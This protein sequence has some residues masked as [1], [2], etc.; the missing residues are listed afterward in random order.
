V[1]CQ[2]YRNVEAIFIDD[3]STDKTAEIIK[4]LITQNSKNEN[5][6]K[7][8]LIINPENQNVYNSRN[9]G[10]K[11]SSGE[12][13]TYLDADD[14][15]LPESME[16]FA[17]FV[18]EFDY[19][20]IIC[21]QYKRIENG[22]LVRQAQITAPPE[23]VDD[24]SKIRKTL[25]T[26]NGFS[27]MLWA[28]LIK[29]SFV[30]EN[31]LLFCGEISHHEDL[32]AVY[33]I[34]NSAQTALFLT[35]PVYV[36]HVDNSS[37]TRTEGDKYKNIYSF[38]FVLEKMTQNLES[39]EDPHAFALFIVQCIKYNFDKINSEKEKSLLP[40]YLKVLEKLKP[41]LNEAAL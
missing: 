15:F 39:E 12:Y 27:E 10:I 9:T 11:N 4:N 23:Y 30:I 22:N 6:I 26:K 13:L 38:A 21:G 18:K 37:L 34:Y 16:T 41:F 31:N 32:L 36:Y 14:E 35:L 20:D 25:Y 24:V 7:Y 8:K 33:K 29:K 5:P 2:K 3:G 1:E 40:R 19:P 28:K 17:S